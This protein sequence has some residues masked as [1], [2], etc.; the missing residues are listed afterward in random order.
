MSEKFITK[1]VIVKTLI[2]IVILF[3]ISTGI[4]TYFFTK[5]ELPISITFRRSLLDSRSL[6]MVI[7]NPTNNNLQIT[8]EGIN[9]HHKQSTKSEVTV[10][11]NK[12]SEFGILQLNW[13]WIPGEKYIINHPNYSPKTGTVP[14]IMYP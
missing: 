11:A 3:A 2:A 7:H 14:S 5:P 4:L 10:F 13:M 9:D 1:P 8:I 12:T 6:V